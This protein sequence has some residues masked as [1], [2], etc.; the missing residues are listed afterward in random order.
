MGSAAQA[1][2]SSSWALRAQA[3]AQPP[4]LG[5]AGTVHI[6]TL[7]AS[8][9]S[10]FLPLDC[11]RVKLSLA[12]IKT[13]QHLEPGP[14]RNLSPLLHH[15]PRKSALSEAVS[16]LDWG[17]EEQAPCVRRPRG[18]RGLAGPCLLVLEGQAS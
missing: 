1:A 2:C 15:Y 7:L 14:H 18:G 8:E 12:L 9:M 13:C 6:Q 5:M 17:Q 3:C 16:I 11:A 10:S 4:P